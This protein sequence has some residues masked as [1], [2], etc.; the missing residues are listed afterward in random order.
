MVL[1]SYLVMKFTSPCLSSFM[2]VSSRIDLLT[3]W[4]IQSRIVRLCRAFSLMRDS[5]LPYS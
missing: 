3:V 4:V 2:I 1:T 5:F